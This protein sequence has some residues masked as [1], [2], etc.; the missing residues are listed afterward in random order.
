MSAPSPPSLLSSPSWD[1]EQGVWVGSRALSTAESE[2]VPDPLVIFGYA[3]SVLGSMRRGP[4]GL[5]ADVIGACVWGAVSCSGRRSPSRTS[6]ASA[7]G[8]PGGR[9][10]GRSGEKASSL[11][12]CVKTASAD[13]GGVVGHCRSTDHRGTPDK[14]GLV[15]TVQ[16]DSVLEAKGKR[17]AKDPPSWVYGVAYEIPPEIRD[18][19][20]GVGQGD[21]CCW[22]G[23]E[24]NGWFRGPVWRSC[25]F[26]WWSVLDELDFREKGGYTRTVVDIYK[27][28]REGDE[29]G[30]QEQQ[31]GKG[32]I[33]CGMTAGAGSIG[34][35]AVVEVVT[36]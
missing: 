2:E 22:Y 29:A 16:P 32:T 36:V 34:C 12:G 28:G 6:S 14:P 13:V 8:C 19:G 5:Q 25:P 35:L 15:C 7:D 10:C 21:G 30:Q 23:S 20:E 27:V 33:E 3:R 17:S 26:V 24:S 31:G 18:E 1:A 11:Q 4:T 9:G